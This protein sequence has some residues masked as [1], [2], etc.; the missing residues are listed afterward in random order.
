MILNRAVGMLMLVTVL[1]FAA[2]G[3]SL[4]DAANEYLED[5]AAP[6]M[7]GT[8]ITQVHGGDYE[9][10]ELVMY[11]LRRP[12]ATLIGADFSPAGGATYYFM[13]M[14]AGE[15]AAYIQHIK[16]MGFT[17]DAEE[18]EN[19]YKAHNGNTQYV[20]FEYEPEGIGSIRAGN[21]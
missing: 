8:D 20:E 7:E 19:Y 18:D 9:W 16:D 6:N 10:D 11:K 4:T 3:C 1:L 14:S 5:N 13:D 2:V 17:K 21:F 15:A 12:N